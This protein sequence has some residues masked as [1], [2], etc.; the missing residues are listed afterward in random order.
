MPRRFRAK[1]FVPDR[2]PHRILAGEFADCL[3]VHEIG[4]TFATVMPG[5]YIPGSPYIHNFIYVY[6]R[7][8]IDTNMY[9]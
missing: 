2:Y 9:I 5:I 4:V 3:R 1:L 7:T 6:T 8:C